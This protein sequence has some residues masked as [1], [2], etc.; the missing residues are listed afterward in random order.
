MRFL[1]MAL[2]L[3]TGCSAAAPPQSERVVEERRFSGVAARGEALMR[4]AMIE[5]HNTARA[6]AGV[7]PLVWNPTL[8]ADAERYA[9]ELARTGRFEH[10]KEPRGPAPEGEN[11]WTGTRGAYRY[12]E[13]AG[14]W[15]DERRDYRRGPTP[16]FSVTGR[17]EDVAHYTQIIWRGTTQFGCATASNATDDYLVCRYTPPGNVVGQMPT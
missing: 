8:A 4:Q 10:S 12:E 1:L 7:P 16:D 6:A 15:V 13:M 5:A 9:R 14:H 2:A 11:L 17:W 3:L